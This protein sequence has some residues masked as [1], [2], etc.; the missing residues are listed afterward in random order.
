MQSL[1]HYKYVSAGRADA[2][3]ADSFLMPKKSHLGRSQK[4]WICE[5]F[6]KSLDS[7]ASVLF[8]F[9]TCKWG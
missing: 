3:D 7:L 2:E 9:L 1:R 5:A 4:L 6:C 8:Y